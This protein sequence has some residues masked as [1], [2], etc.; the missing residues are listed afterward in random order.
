MRQPQTLNTYEEYLSDPTIPQVEP[1]G[2]DSVNRYSQFLAQEELPTERI[3]PTNR[4]SEFLIDETDLGEVPVEFTRPEPV[5]YDTPE[6]AQTAENL[7][8]AELAS[9]TSYK[10]TLAEYMTNRLGERGEQREDETDEEYLKRFVSHVRKFETNTV[11]LGT[12]LDW[13]RRANTEERMKFGYLYSELDR[14]PSFYQEGGA[15]WTVALRDFGG[16]LLTDPFSYIGFG[17]GAV[18]T[19]AATRGVIEA[20]KTGGKKLAIEQAAKYSAQRMLS[21]GAGRVAATGIAAEAAVNAVHDRQLQEIEILAN[22]LGPD[23]YNPLRTIGAAGLGLGFGVAGTFLSRGLNPRGILG[24]ATKQFE[25]HKGYGTALK[26]RQRAATKRAVQSSQ[27]ATSETATGIFD[28]AAGREQLATLGTLKK[29]GLTQI[30]FNTEIMKRVGRAITDTVQTLA[31]NGKLGQIVDGDTKASEVIAKVVTD[32]LKAVQGRT[33]GQIKSKTRTMLTG[34]GGLLEKLELERAKLPG[35]EADEAFDDALEAAISR[36]GLSVEQFTDAMGATYS[37]AA[38]VLATA[39]K[40]GKIMDSLGRLDPKLEKILIEKSDAEKTAGVMGNFWSGF[41]RLD[42]ERR[43]L[44]V[45]MFNTTVR[46]VYGGTVR[47]GLESAA[48]LIEAVMYQT[49]RGFE[50]ARTGQSITKAVNFK[51]IVRDGFGK[52][53][54]LSTSSNTTTL[55]EGLLAHNRRLAGRISKTLQEVSDNETLSAV[56]RQA[57][58][59]NVAQDQF[60]RRGIFVNNIDKKLRRAGIIVDKPTKPGQF[61]HLGEFVA[62]GKTLPPKILSDAI[63]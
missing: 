53:A 60:F 61:K 21:T 20:L 39:S 4:Y 54:R 7:T 32:R 26:R 24:S 58:T 1:T 56:S 22:D 31:D 45:T 25:T 18:A 30:Q 19:K 55:A 50:A 16:A 44:M 47:L 3:Q 37:D 36:A 17:A 48:D 57:N 35:A 5:E 52:L 51:D 11:Q 27:K 38:K 14:L 41:R 12:Q 9:D 29:T 10:E 49:A 63:D 40:V 46:N 8:Y 43:A 23:A 34:R 15:G 6:A 33:A 28:T 42:R 2:P 13:V 62:S 59:L